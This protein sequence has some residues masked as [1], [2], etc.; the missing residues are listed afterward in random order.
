[1][2]NKIIVSILCSFI[3]V[4]ALLIYIALSITPV[5]LKRNSFTYE[6]GEQISTQAS[7]YVNANP[8][9]LKNIKLD[10]SAVSTEVGVYHAS[11][12]YLGNIQQF[13][14]KVV[15]TVKPKVQLKQVQFNIHLG[16]TICASDLIKEV[17]DY[18]RTT[19][20]FYDEESKQKNKTK[21]YTKEGS[22]IEKIIVEDEHGNQSAALRVK[23][24]VEGNH[25]LPI[26]KGADDAEI[27]IGE[28]FDLYDG[29][30]A[31]DDIEGDITDRINVDGA[32][33]NQEAGTYQLTYTVSDKDGNTAKVI[34]KVT[35]IEDDN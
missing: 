6:Y 18:S 12:D 19:V 32:V 25:I 10:L 1:M 4:D 28:E 16:K 21:T 24:V 34:R 13:E 20:Y 33:N 22:Y 7:D 23:I 3:I 5:K 11:V 26:I 30:T 31:S 15:D 2:R 35:V 29:V 9:V 8:T 27:K 17:D 14:I